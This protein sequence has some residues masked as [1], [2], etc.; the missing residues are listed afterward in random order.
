MKKK[1]SITIV[2]LFCCA[3]CYPQ[4]NATGLVED[5]DAHR[6]IPRK[7]DLVHGDYRG[8]PSSHSLVQYCPTPKSQG[9][10][11]TCTAWAS[12]F[13][14]RT[15]AEAVAQG[16]TDKDKINAEAFS[17]WF[18]YTNIK[19]ADDNLCKDGSAIPHALQ[20]MKTKGVC[21]YTDYFSECQYSIPL[22]IFTKASAY[23][24]DDYFN[25]FVHRHNDGSHTNDQS[26]VDKVKKAISENRPVVIGMNVYDSFHACYGTDMWNGIQSLQVSKEHGLHAMCVVGYD[27]NKYGGAFQIMN[28]WGTQ[29]GQG[30]FVWVRYSDFM[31]NVWS[32]DEIYVRPKNYPMP[33]IKRTTLSGSLKLQLATGQTMSGT[34]TNQVN[35]I[36]CYK[37]S[38]AYSSGTRYRI[39]ISNNQPA[40][41]Y[42]ISSDLQNNVSKLFPP[43][44][45]TS[46]ALVY[47]NNN[48]AIPDESWWVQLDNTVG[49]DYTCV[50]YS[51]EQLDINSV[52]SKLQSAQ[53][54]FYDKLSTALGANLVPSNDIRFGQNTIDFN[55]QTNKIVVPIIIEM[56]HK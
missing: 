19:D 49:T 8:V 47:K 53:G 56:T 11:G 48:I 34:L 7:A 21:K 13:A 3:L 46:P 25:L 52:M 38:D 4:Q 30:G 33:V 43:D 37:I 24:I 17:P 18:V 35:N 23:K 32:A 6:A 41:V 51:A 12:A 29:F 36:K 16:W 22:N 39:Y 50:L 9:Q 40:Y 20:L 5:F 42:V 10:F 2:F 1:L 45:N 26:K 15:I 54:S 27:D 44:D 28:S 14:A 31:K 55:A